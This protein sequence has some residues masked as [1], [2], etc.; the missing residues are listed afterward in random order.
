MIF[1]DQRMV[2]A[3]TTNL[4]DAKVGP[5]ANEVAKLFMPAGK[6]E[7]PGAGGQ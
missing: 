2:V 4:S 7:T 6:V 5:I 3:V 1:P